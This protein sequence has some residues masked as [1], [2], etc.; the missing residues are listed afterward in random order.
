MMPKVLSSGHIVMHNDRFPYR[1]RPTRN[2][3]CG[4]SRVTSPLGALSLNTYS[5]NRV[6]NQ[7]TLSMR[8]VVK[9]YCSFYLSDMKCQ[10]LAQVESQQQEA[11]RKYQ[12]GNSP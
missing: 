10:K 8:K 5:N 3:R 6:K 11:L 12:V 7:P 4:D 1:R 9:T 2:V